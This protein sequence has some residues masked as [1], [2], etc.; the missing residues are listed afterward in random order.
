M[1]EENSDIEGTEEEQIRGTEE[2][3]IQGTGEEQIQGTGEQEQWEAPPLPEEIEKPQEEEPE[4]SEMGTIGN[5]FFEPG[6]TF[7]DLR[8]KPRFLIAFVIIAVV[9][10]GFLFAFQQKMGTE[11]IRRFV[12]TQREK[13]PQFDSLSDEQKSNQIDLQMTIGRIVSYAYPVVLAIIF[14][15]GGLLY[16]LGSKAMGGSAR[17]T[18]G[19]SVFIYS[20][21][22]PTLVSQIGNFLILFLKSADEIDIAASQRGLINANPTLFFGGKETPVLTTL[23]S[24]V[25]LFA[26]WGLV[27]AAIGL[28]RV[29]KISKGAAWAVVLILTLIGITFRVIGAVINGVPS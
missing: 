28:Q 18:Q 26:I 6:R 10:V 21:L 3:Q 22:P 4:M 25:D 27:L 11:R 2:E 5:I 7:E 15:L 12:T 24:T 17:F 14:V 8:R 9:S 19:L 20:S 23:I 1:N 13:S 29:A 16:W